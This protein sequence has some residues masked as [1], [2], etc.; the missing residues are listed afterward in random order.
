MTDINQVTIIGRLV[1]DVEA[2]YTGTGTAIMHFTVAVN[3]RS[4][5]SG[6]NW[7][8][9]P[10]FIDCTYFPKVPETIEPI[11]VKGKQIA[12][13]GSLKQDKWVDQNG[14]NRSRLGVVVNQLQFLGS[15]RDDG[16][17][18]APRQQQQ[19]PYSQASQSPSR[20]AEEPP[21]GPDQ[22]EDDQIPF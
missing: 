2:K 9:D 21:K 18:P 16:D 20:Q 3:R 19:K 5:D 14:Q 4:K 12:I 1:K 13:Q 22:F 6:G 11:L 10:S 8:D 15:S 7:N 17:A